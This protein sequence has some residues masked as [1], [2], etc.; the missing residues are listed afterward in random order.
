MVPPFVVMNGLYLIVYF[1]LPDW[2]LVLPHPFIPLMI[3]ALFLGAMYWL[4]RDCGKRLDFFTVY[5]FYSCFILLVGVA[6]IIQWPNNP[7]WKEH[8]EVMVNWTGMKMIEFPIVFGLALM[9]TAGICVPAF[10]LKS[11]YPKIG[12]FAMGPNVLIIFSHFLDAS[13]TY[14]AIDIHGY[15]EKHVLPSFFID[16]FGTALVMFPL[17]AMIIIPF[18]FLLDIY[19]LKEMPEDKDARMDYEIL[20]GL[21]KLVVIMVGLA[22]GL[23]DVF[24]L[25]MGI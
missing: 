13:S 19:F 5:T 12:A 25:G 10:L 8:Y 6:L 15:Y 18:I 9:V 4:Q 24:R 2:Y 7:V 3:T 20:F 14:R 17:K 16:F 1:F 21:V 23:R 22:P 11:K